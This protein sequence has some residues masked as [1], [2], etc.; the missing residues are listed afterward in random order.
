MAR[1]QRDFE[2]LFP[3][4]MQ[5][6]KIADHRDMNAQLMREVDE[7][8][9]T[10]P[11]GRPV[12]WSCDVYTTISNNYLLHERPGFRRLNQHF[13]ENAAR[14]GRALD[15]PM[16]THGVRI[17]M[18]WLNAYRRGHSQERHTHVNYVFSAIYYLKAP[19]GASKLL[20]HAPTADVMMAPRMREQTDLN[21]RYMEIEP[22]EGLMLIF[23]GN[24]RHG[25]RAS[26]IDE[27]RIS[28]AMNANL[29]QRRPS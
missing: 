26:N 9:A 2:L 12:S 14:Y 7:I 13:V 15:Y 1:V 17:D 10:T 25:V 4:V 29:V 16:H 20:I 23:S 24:L 11:N 19:P 3:T 8:R 18:C 28:I 6:T 27:E 21:T 5:I 22:E